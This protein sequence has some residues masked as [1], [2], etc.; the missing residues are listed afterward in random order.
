MAESEKFYPSEENLG[1]TCLFWDLFG[2]F[3]GCNFPYVQMEGR[4]SCEGLIDDVCLFLKDGRRPKSLTEEQIR[5]LKI[6]IPSFEEKLYIPPG[7]TSA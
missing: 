7:E 2:G 3:T 5:E 6:R 4:V 1:K